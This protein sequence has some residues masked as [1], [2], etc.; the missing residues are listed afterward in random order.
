MTN[1]YRQW[2]DSN[3]TNKSFFNNHWYSPKYMMENFDFPN[4]FKANRKLRFVWIKLF[5]ISYLAMVIVARCLI[6]QSKRCFSFFVYKKQ[7]NLRLKSKN[8]TYNLITNTWYFVKR[9][10]I[11]LELLGSAFIHQSHLFV[12]NVSIYHSLYYMLWK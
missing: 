3:P 1:A 5:F 11:T 8:K 4:H 7:F 2:V 9:F 12:I 6:K 10:F